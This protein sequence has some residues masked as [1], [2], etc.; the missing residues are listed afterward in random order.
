MRGRL[1]DPLW[2]NTLRPHGAAFWIDVADDLYDLSDLQIIERAG[3]AIDQDYRVGRR[4]ARAA[5]DQSA[6]AADV[7]DRAGQATN[8]TSAFNPHG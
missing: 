3:F 1:A 8:Q 5:N 6:V 4:N 7:G 2:G